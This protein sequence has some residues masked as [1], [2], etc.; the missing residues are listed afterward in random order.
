MKNIKDITVA[1]QKVLMRADFNVPFD[2]HGKISDDTRINGVLPTINYLIEQGARIILC[3]HCGRPKGERLAK[4]SLAP[5][6]GRLS[7]LLCR[8]IALAPDCVGPEVQSMV[9][10]LQD[11]D[12]LLLENLRFHAEEQK[13]DAGL[14][15]S[16]P[17]WP[18]SM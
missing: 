14:R 18:T 3:S 5:V 8:K 16:L 9:N 15:S 12:I 10:S 2:E 11:G 4:F 7:E 1:G 6:A 13:N 17:H